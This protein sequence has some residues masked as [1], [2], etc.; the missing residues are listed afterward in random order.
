M[1][2]FIVPIGIVPKPVM[3]VVPVISPLSPVMVDKSVVVALAKSALLACFKTPPI[4]SPP[5]ILCVFK[6]NHGISLV[7]VPLDT[8]YNCTKFSVGYVVA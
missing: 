1:R 6:T 7:G 8:L 3:V 4:V 5:S 2:Y